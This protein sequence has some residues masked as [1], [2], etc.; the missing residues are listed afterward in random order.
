MR[1][2]RVARAARPRAVSAVQPL[3]GLA[4]LLDL[5]RPLHGQRPPAPRFKP[6]AQLLGG[7]G[8]LGILRGAK[9]HRAKGSCDRDHRCSSISASRRRSCSTTL[10]L[11]VPR[12]QF[13]QAGQGLAV[14][15][16]ELDQLR[17]RGLAPPRH[18]PGGRPARRGRRSPGRREPIGRQVPQRLDRLDRMVRTR[19]P[20]RAGH[21]R[22]RDR[23]AAGPGTSASHSSALSNRASRSARLALPS[24]TRSSS[25]AL[26]P[27]SSSSA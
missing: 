9:A 19:S 13:G 4:A 15:G 12:G 5:Q 21:A 11:P 10:G 1:S 24:Q 20:S 8:Q 7:P 22:R 14:C 18:Y 25:G 23:R 26:R 6:F 2:A 3:Q 16:I 27:A 17:Q